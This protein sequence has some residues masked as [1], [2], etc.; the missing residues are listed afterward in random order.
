MRRHHDFAQEFDRAVGSVKV[1][2]GVGVRNRLP[3]HVVDLNGFAAW[4]TIFA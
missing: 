1:D 2:T 3:D 4:D